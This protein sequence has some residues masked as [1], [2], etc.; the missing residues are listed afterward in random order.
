M[1]LFWISGNH[2]SSYLVQWNLNFLFATMNVSFILVEKPKKERELIFQR[3]GGLFCGRMEGLHDKYAG[4]CR[5]IKKKL[6]GWNICLQKVFFCCSF[7]KKFTSR[8]LDT[9]Q[10]FLRIIVHL[11]NFCNSNLQ[12]SKGHL[13]QLILNNLRLTHLTFKCIWITFEYIWIT[14]ECI[15]I[16]F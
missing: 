7:A 9:K 13:T 12:H 6:F 8:P 2:F 3:P 1:N 4:S 14:F 16:N 15:W 10:I 11:S 5:P